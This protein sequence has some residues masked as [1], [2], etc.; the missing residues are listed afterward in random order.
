M[1]CAGVT[2]KNSEDARLVEED[3]LHGVV[4]GDVRVL[5]ELEEVLVG[6]ADLGAE[7]GLAARRTRST[8]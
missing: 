8:R 4:H 6:R 3:V 5:H 1:T 7:A 2:P